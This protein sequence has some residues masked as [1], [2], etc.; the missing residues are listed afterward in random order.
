MRNINCK[1]N[2]HNWKILDSK[3][4][5][6]IEEE[7]RVEIMSPKCKHNEPCC[8]HYPFDIMLHGASLVN[9]R[10][11]KKVCVNCEKY[12]DEITQY[13]LKIKPKV[14]KEIKLEEQYK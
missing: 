9:I 14:E 2:I 4:Y 10:Y 5:A 8:C 13:K 3:N 12:V 7:L 11:A 6:E 1:L